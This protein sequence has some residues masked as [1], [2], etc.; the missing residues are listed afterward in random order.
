MCSGRSA[1]PCSFDPPTACCSSRPGGWPSK[2]WPAWKSRSS[3]APSAAPTPTTGRPS[4]AASS[5]ACT[6]N[7]PRRDHHPA[8]PARSSGLAA[9]ARQRIVTR[10]GDQACS[11]PPTVHPS[12]TCLAPSTEQVGQAVVPIH[13]HVR[14]PSPWPR[15]PPRTRASLTHTA[16][17]PPHRSRAATFTLRGPTPTTATRRA[18]TLPPTAQ[19]PD[20]A[21]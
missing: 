11:A 4:E 15:P 1:G 19:N 3:S 16:P 14:L 5:P 21:I 2:S 6:A 13:R 17:T 9:G 8:E 12:P 20:R 18:T 7:R 10:N